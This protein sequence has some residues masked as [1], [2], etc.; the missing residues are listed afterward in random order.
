MQCD[1]ERSSF[2]KFLYISYSD[3]IASVMVSEVCKI[4]DDAF[5]K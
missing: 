5:A 3:R 4:L 2:A 1:L